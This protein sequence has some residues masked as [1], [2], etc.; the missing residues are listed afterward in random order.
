[1][2]GRWLHPKRAGGATPDGVPT[3]LKGEYGDAVKADSF[4]RARIE[5]G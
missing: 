4:P 5:E 2:S 1:M 3:G